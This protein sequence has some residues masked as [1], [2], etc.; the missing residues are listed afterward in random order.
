MWQLFKLSRLSTQVCP[1]VFGGNPKRTSRKFRQSRTTSPPLVVYGG[2]MK[3]VDLETRAVHP[4]APILFANLYIVIA[5]DMHLDT[6]FNWLAQDIKFTAEVWTTQRKSCDAAKFLYFLLGI[7]VR[8]PF[9]PAKK[10]T[11]V[12]SPTRLIQG[13]TYY[14]RIVP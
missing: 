2:R 8:P 4:S 1:A 5:V 3:A 7:W 9:S 14:R 6:P 12:W 11:A 10:P 13:N